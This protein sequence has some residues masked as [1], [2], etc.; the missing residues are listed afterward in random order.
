MLKSIKRDP[1]PF[2]H[3]GNPI[4][5]DYKKNTQKRGEQY[6]VHFPCEMGVVLSGTYRRIY[7]DRV[8]DLNRGGVWWQGPWEPHGLATV[9]AASSAIVIMCLPTALYGLST[10]QGFSLLTYLPFIR[11][12]IRP[13]L[14]PGPAERTE[15]MRRA[16]SLYTEY[17]QKPPG[18]ETILRLD[19]L[20]LVAGLVRTVP[21]EKDF[22]GGRYP[23]ADRI[24]RAVDFTNQN[25]R[26]KITLEDAAKEA[27]LGR[28]LFIR[29][30]K[31]VMGMPFVQYLIRCR[32]AGAQEDIMK[33]EAKLDFVAR[34]WGFFD[35]S[36]LSKCYKAHF[37]H[38][39]EQERQS[40]G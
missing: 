19:L 6:D 39:P 26:R 18:W 13:R 21:L 22:R 36:H 25:L 4:Y 15:V 9:T 11:P 24:L 31:Q 28:T 3:E 37:G 7:Q 27:G 35:G 30:F 10:G 5:V 14:Q 34:R 29:Y 32:L 20:R 1:I 38:P 8:V 2:V 17:S 23:A 33:G 16:E 12:E 40:R